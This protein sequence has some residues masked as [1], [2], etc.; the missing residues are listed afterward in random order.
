MVDIDSFSVLVDDAYGD[1]F[2]TQ[3]SRDTE[4]V[5]FLEENDGFKTVKDDKYS[6]KSDFK[7]KTFEK[8]MVDQKAKEKKAI[9]N[10][11][12]IGMSQVMG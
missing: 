3:L 2:I 8:S 7:D 10:E 12:N 6:D 1:L 5:V 11:S 4:V 9:R